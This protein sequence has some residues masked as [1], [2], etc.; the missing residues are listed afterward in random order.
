MFHFLVNRIPRERTDDIQELRCAAATSH[1]SS[2]TVKVNKI[3]I[4]FLKETMAK[5][6]LSTIRTERQEWALKQSRTYMRPLD[7]FKSQILYFY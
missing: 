4:E 1:D 7:F 5:K 2:T 6:D 3:L